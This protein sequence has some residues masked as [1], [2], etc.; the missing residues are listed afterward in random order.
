LIDP[1]PSTVNG[2]LVSAWLSARAERDLDRV[3]SLTTAD[4]IWHSPVEGR[5]IGR[6]AVIEEIR[7]AF[8]NTDR[9]ETALVSLRCQSTTAEAQIR[10]VATRHGKSL[11]SVQ[12]LSFRVENGQ[13]AE[14]HVQVDDQ[15][16]VEDFW[17]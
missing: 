16:Q 13:I 10:N 15:A 9:F 5:R 2:D 7:R 17:R 14:I 11:D 6:A 12:T 3:A 4:A 1:Q 8:E